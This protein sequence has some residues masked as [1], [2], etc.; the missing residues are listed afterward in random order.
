MGVESEGARR[1]KLRVYLN[2][3]AVPSAVIRNQIEMWREIRG[4]V[5]ARPAFCFR[6]A[7]GM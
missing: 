6:L 7:A 3:V 1:G 5:R 4:R 2:H